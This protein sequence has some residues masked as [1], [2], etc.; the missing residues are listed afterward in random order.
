MQRDLVFSEALDLA[1]AAQKPV[2]KAPWHLFVIGSAAVLWSLLGIF[3]FLATATLYPPYMARFPAEAQAYWS[4]LPDWLYGTWALG[5]FAGLA[6]AALLVRRRAV[7]VR[8]LIFSTAATMLTMG[9]SF[10]LPAPDYDGN[11]VS[12]VCIIVVSLL[13]LNYAMHQAKQGVLR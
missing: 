4:A 9:A 2:Q 7:A 5:V 1:P 13:V 3:D 6:G 8:V 11:R 12:A 10:S